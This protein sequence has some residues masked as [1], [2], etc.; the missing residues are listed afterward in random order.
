MTAVLEPISDLLI[1][2]SKGKLA[3]FKAIV[4]GDPAPTVGW[5]RN[6]G[7][8]SDS[9]KYIIVYESVTGEHQLQVPN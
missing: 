4:T 2:L 9:E 1:L 7:E 6:N 8:I 5:T 3:V